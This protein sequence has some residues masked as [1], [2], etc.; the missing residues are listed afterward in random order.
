[1]ET[2]E[3][4]DGPMDSIVVRPG[5]PVRG[6]VVV[7]Q[8]AFGLTDHI[9]RVCERFA[10]EGFL[11]VAPALFHRTGAPVL[12]YGDFD[13]IKPHFAA[14]NPQGIE[15]DL[16]VALHVLDDA[17][18]APGQQG[19]VGYCMGGTL[20]LWAGTTFDLGAAVS[21]YGG[22]VLEGRFGLPSLLDLAPSLGCP[23][24]GHYGDLDQGIP[25]DQVELLRDAVAE[26]S[27]PTE[28]HRYAEAGHGFNCDA[29][30]AFHE[31]SSRLAWERTLGWFG[32]HLAAD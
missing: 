31:P 24:Q 5:V 22:G 16:A 23:W 9:G 7:I 8:E 27:V 20:A 19:I 10:S 12:A 30:D 1:M 11:A 3:T 14:L 4:P 18:L 32:Q 28:L 21:Y 25:V 17:G 15:T 26:A 29:R 13:A 2:L 6:G